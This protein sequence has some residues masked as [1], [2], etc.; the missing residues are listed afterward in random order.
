[1]K[2]GIDV[3]QHNGVIDFAKVKSNSDVEFVILRDGFG[4]NTIDKKF[5]DNVNGFK[6]VGINVLG[7]YHFSYALSAKDAE[8]EAVFAVNT[9]KEAGLGKDIIIFYDLEYDSVRYATQN[10][11]KIDKAACIK[12]TE[13]FCQKVKALGYT[14]GV[15]FNQDYYKNMYTPE[16]LNKY[17]CWLADYNGDPNYPCSFQQYS[18]TGK[19]PGMT[20][21]VDMNYDFRK[22]TTTS[23]PAATTTSKPAASTSKPASGKKSNEEVAKDVLAGKYGNGDERKKKLTAEGYDYNAVQAIVNKLSSGGGT[24]TPKKA[25]PAQSFSKSLA[26]TYVVNVMKVNMRYKPG[27]LSDGN[28]MA[29]LTNG[30][31]VQMYGYFTSVN[32]QKWFYVQSGTKEGYILETYLTKK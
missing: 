1:M 20:G 29:T 32:G 12:Y 3:S 24:S 30:T 21:N 5:K 14:P 26:G 11:V 23:K 4:R 25:S 2:R 27:D 15:Y 31:K 17:V 13:A 19:V 10:G 9:A 22:G 6:K 28:V 8:N 16:C 18:S 7:T